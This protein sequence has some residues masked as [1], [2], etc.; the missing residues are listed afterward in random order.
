MTQDFQQVLVLLDRKGFEPSL[1]QGPC[2]RRVVRRMP[3]LGVRHA[4]SQRMN[5]DK[6]PSPR[7]HSTRCQR[8]GSTHHASNRTG[9]RCFASPSTRSNAW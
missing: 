9:T 8:L 6:S 3:T 1:I 7:G 2:A 4:L 5:S